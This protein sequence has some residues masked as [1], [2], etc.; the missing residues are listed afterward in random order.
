MA[1]RCLCHL[2]DLLRLDTA[3]QQMKVSQEQSMARKLTS[4]SL[5][6]LKLTYP[7]IL[8]E[9]WAPPGETLDIVE[10]FREMFID[11]IKHAAKHLPADWKVKILESYDAAEPIGEAIESMDS[12]KS[13]RKA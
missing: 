1:L 10:H 9:L 13:K 7:Q 4:C 12:P 11:D 5:D 3:H 6:K 2:W 8:I